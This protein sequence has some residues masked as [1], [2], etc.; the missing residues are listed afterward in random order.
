[1]R[2]LNINH[3]IKINDQDKISYIEPKGTPRPSFFPVFLGPVHSF[4]LVPPLKSQP[5]QMVSIYSFD[6]CYPQQKCCNI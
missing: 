6:F 4:P 1:M 2:A 3:L 5:H